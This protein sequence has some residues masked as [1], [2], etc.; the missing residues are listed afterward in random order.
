VTRHD[1]PVVG[2]LHWGNVLEDFLRPNGL[3]LDDYCRSFR[4]SW[5]FGAVDALRTAGVESVLYVISIDATRTVRRVH[6]PTG[7]TVVVLPAPRAYATLARRMR[8]PYGRT[9]EETFGRRG[10]LWAGLRELSP[11]LATPVRALAHELRRDGCSALVA[12]EYEFPRFDVLALRRPAGVPVFG[13]FQG[14]DY[15]RWRLERLTRPIAMR[16]AAGLVVASE[17]EADRLRRTYA[18]LPPLARLPNPVDVEL[19]RPEDGSAARAR[20]GVLATARVAVWHGRVEIRKKGLDVL[21]DAWGR[22]TTPGRV[23]L[24]VGRGPDLDELA[25]RVRDA[26]DVI[27]VGRLVDDRDELRGLLAAGD[28]YVFPSRHE[29]FAVAPVEAAACGLPVVAA[30]VRGI[31]DAFPD[32][33]G[34]GAV[35][36]PRE[37]ATALAAAL[38]RLLSDGRLAAELGGRARRRAVEAF[39]PAAVGADLRRF[40]LRRP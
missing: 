36:V 33:E 18:R 8:N 13:W 25:E 31:D 39:S 3:T 16:R 20:L 17:A 34:S 40:L 2:L 23:L 19:W 37:D 29:G 11:Y 27:L 10:P 28:A 9:A 14:G 21:L 30:R 4:G 1:A 32:G 7:A 15:R 12:Q 22:M 38:D 26:R 24:L 5:V 35:I 6:E